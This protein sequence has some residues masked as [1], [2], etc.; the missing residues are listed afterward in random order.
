MLASTTL[1]LPKK[2]SRRKENFNDSVIRIFIGLIQMT[3]PLGSSVEENL[4]AALESN[5]GNL[6]RTYLLLQ[7]GV[8]SNLDLVNAGAAANSGAASN[9]RAIIASILSGACPSSPS[10]AAQ[11]GRAIGGLLRT[12]GE[13]SPET[14]DYLLSLRA[15]LDEHAES[16]EAVQR[17]DTEIGA[18][19]ELLERTFESLDGVY[20][21][22]FPTYFRTVQKSDPERFLYKIGKTDNSSEGRIKEQQ[23][24]TN[25]PEDPWMLR[26][27]RSSAISP[28][29]IESRFHSMLVAAGHGRALGKRAGREWFFTNLDFLDEIAEIL[30]LE[31]H[32]P[33]VG[34]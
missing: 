9:T 17:E 25:M 5:S 33:I 32:R 21:Y 12:Y 10:I 3:A 4:R 24:A 8:S 29:E 23:R 19:S 13:F 14:K 11:V 16:S 15:T 7:E 1:W 28:I 22:T 18:A 20:V 30:N 6:G 26:V 31:I 34:G 27:Y 2:S